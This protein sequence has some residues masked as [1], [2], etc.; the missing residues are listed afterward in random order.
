MEVVGPEGLLELKGAFTQ[1]Y[2]VCAGAVVGIHALMRCALM[3]SALVQAE[4]VTHEHK[5]GN[6]E[7]EPF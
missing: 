2:D 6:D 1:R 4:A 3:R 5:D 7:M